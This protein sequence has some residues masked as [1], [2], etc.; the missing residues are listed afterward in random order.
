[1]NQ[2]NN[3]IYELKQQLTALN[4]KLDKQAEINDKAIRRAINAGADKM[5]SL[6]IKSVLL[7]VIAFV[8]VEAIVILQG[9][10]IPFAI[11]TAAFMGANALTAV[12]FKLRLMD[13]D[14]GQDM[15][16]T[17]NQMLRYKKFNRSSVM[18]ELPIA[19]VWACW[20]CFEMV[21][22]LG[23]NDTKS[24]LPLFIGMAVGGV[25]GGLC[26]YYGLYRPSMREA[27][28]IIRQIKELEA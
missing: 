2:D 6:G 3:E 10:S 20:Y 9:V 22:I 5:H 19:I 13:I 11:A 18:I 27:D 16:T 14:P 7:C 21:R 26:G 4:A 12:F 24:M 25:I 15:V 28:G 23:L 8:F 17:A 1:M